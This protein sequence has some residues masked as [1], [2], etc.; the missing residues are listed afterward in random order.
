MKERAFEL[1]RTLNS[2]DAVFLAHRSGNVKSSVLSCRMSSYTDRFVA[3]NC[4]LLDCASVYF[5]SR[6]V[7]V[8]IVSEGAVVRFI[9]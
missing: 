2:S 3:G 5:R 7:S 1:F 4:V 9:K 6:D 8:C